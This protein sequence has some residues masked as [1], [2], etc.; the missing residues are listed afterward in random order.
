MCIAGGL[1]H[2]VGDHALINAPMSVTHR[3]DD[4]AVNVTDCREKNKQ[5][6]KVGLVFVGRIIEQNI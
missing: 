4:Q 3:A 6:L 5:V 2:L 1:S